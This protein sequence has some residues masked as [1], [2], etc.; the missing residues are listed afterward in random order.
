MV[1]LRKNRR[2]G[3]IIATAI[4]YAVLAVI[5]CT[6][7]FSQEDSPDYRGKTYVEIRIDDDGV[8]LVDSSGTETLVPLGNTR[9]DGS[10]E[11]E[12]GLPRDFNVDPDK[13]PKKR[14]TIN[15]IGKSVIV[16][17]DEHVYG[18]VTALG[19]DVTIR[20]LVEGDVTSTGRVRLESDAVVVGNVV[21][22]SVQRSSGSKVGGRVTETDLVPGAEVPWESSNNDPTAA[23]IVCIVY[24]TVLLLF[25]FVTAMLFP[26]A[27]DRVKVLYGRNILKTLLF[28]FI[29]WLLIL[30]VYILLLITII[31]IPVAV[32]GMPLAVLASAFLGGA[33]F[34]LF[35]SD[36]LKTGANGKKES[37][38]A[39]VLIGFVVV[40]IPT[41]GFFIGLMV[42]SEALSIVSGIVAGLLNLLVITLGFGGSVLT[43]FGTR[44]YHDGRVTFKVEVVDDDAQASAEAPRAE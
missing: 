18:S 22:K 44:D 34:S 17:S 20:G 28:G 26:K 35:V 38:A 25:T 8:I 19:G 5:T 9:D 33:A 12:N 30:P 11:D 15:S 7:V 6:A 43:R 36:L 13:F 24:M 3:L 16:E 40:Q 32:L 10:F 14:K 41:L 42:A 39:N 2:V 4:A 23:F 27:T 31:G 21:G 29:V 1:S 37:R